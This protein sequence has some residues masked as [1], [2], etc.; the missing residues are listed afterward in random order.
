MLI[1]IGENILSVHKNMAKVVNKTT[2]WLSSAKD[3]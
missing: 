1:K 2:Q 3:S